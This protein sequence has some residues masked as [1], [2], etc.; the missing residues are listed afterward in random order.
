MRVADLITLYDFN[1]WANA[2]LMRALERLSEDDLT[3]V[4]GGG[5]DSI[6]NT[7][8]HIMSAEWGWLGR[9]GGPPRGPRL[10]PEDFPSLDSIKQT[11]TG[12]EEFVRTFLTNLTEADLDRPVSYTNDAGEPRTMALGELMQHAANHG[13]HHKGQISLML[14]LLGSDPEDLDLLIYYGEKRGINPW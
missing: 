4:V 11:W 10:R 13:V 9:C 1:Y 12:L 3:K 8:V 6:R 5:H 14:R 2:R 7:L